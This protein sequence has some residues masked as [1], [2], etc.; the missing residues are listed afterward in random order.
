MESRSPRPG[1]RGRYANHSFVKMQPSELW[2]RGVVMPFSLEIAQR[3]AAWD[4][5]ESA[6]VEFLPIGDQNLFEQLWNIRLFSEI[7]YA[8][9]TIIADYESEW[10]PAEK[11]PVAA[12]V[13]R[14]L[15]DQNPNGVIGGFLE[16]LL[17][18]IRQAAELQMPLYFEC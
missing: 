15:L 7:N 5:D 3:I 9:G 18:M 8:C 4:V 6:H 13:V 16:R 1:E 14:R 2:R 10:L 12:K 11:L 17:V